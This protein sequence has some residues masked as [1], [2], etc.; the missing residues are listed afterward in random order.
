M[1]K[2]FWVVAIAAGAWGACKKSEKR[3]TAVVT[4]SA[5]TN[6]SATSAQLGGNITNTGNSPITDAGICWALHNPPT[7]TDSLIKNQTTTS[8][9]YSVN[10]VN[11]SANTIYYF[12]AYV[13][14][15]VGTSYGAVDSFT[16][17]K[18]VPTVTTSAIANNEALSVQCG[19]AVTND[20][21]ATVTERGLV[22]ATTSNPVKGNSKIGSSSTA[23]TFTD[24]ITGLNLGV[25]Y[26][27]RAYATNS[28]GT[29][30][31]NDVSFVVSSVGTVTD[32]DGNVYATVTI[33]TQTWTTTNLK[34]TH[35]KNGDPIIDGYTSLNLDT[36]VTTPAY[37]FPNGDTSTNAV[38]GKLYTIGATIDPR[39]LAPTGWHVST[40]KDWYTLE[41]NQGLTA[42][43]TSKNPSDFGDRGTIAGKLLQGGSS[44]LNLQLAGFYCP[45]CGGYS[46]FG[47][48]GV[49]LTSTIYGTTGLEIMRY[50]GVS[51]PGI[52]TRDY[53]I[54]PGSVRL[55]KD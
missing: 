12:R 11:L 40:D 19:G 31:G 23:A 16:T 32:Y 51:G 46:N 30:Y 52:I 37:T 14:N 26:H 6:I 1:K 4:T 41:F 13:I 2:V 45:G 7:L 8:G 15:G 49:Y 34:V 36:V 39:G 33:G 10:L 29:G 35:Y 42:A 9:T 21:G 50:F 3:A 48:A 44:G 18:G 43:D 28:Y 38:Y 17:A 55:V 27:I 20:G 24:T 5:A 25:T 54:L 22:W 53:N 47:T